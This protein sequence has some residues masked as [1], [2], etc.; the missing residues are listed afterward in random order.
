MLAQSDGRPKHVGFGGTGKFLQTVRTR[1]D[2]H[3]ASCPRSD[4]RLQRKGAFIAGWFLA[5]YGLLLTVRA[6]WVQL[7][8]CLSYALAAAAWGF[9]IFHDANHGA[10]TSSRRVPA[11]EPTELPCAWTGAILLAPQA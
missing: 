8:W 11:G 2:E 5:S 9:N 6:G 4:G 7:L 3:L 10:F 1:V